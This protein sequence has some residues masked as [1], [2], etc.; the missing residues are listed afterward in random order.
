MYADTLG[1]AW[2][3][4]NER[5][6]RN[7]VRAFRELQEEGVVEIITCGAT[8]G[9]LPLISTPEAKRAQISIAVSNYRKHFGRKPRGIWLPE[10]AYE[11]GIEN[12]LADAGIE[13]FISDT[14]AILYGEPRPRYGVY[15]PVRCPNGYVRFVRNGS[16]NTEA[17]CCPQP[18]VSPS[19]RGPTTRR[20]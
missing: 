19:G 7:L 16:V 14:H 6:G 2:R 15:A 8:H 5:Y 11:P 4:W 10:C 20:A 13:Y 3:L 1:A 9:F 17:P 18:W 12:L